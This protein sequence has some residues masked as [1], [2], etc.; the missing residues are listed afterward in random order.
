MLPGYKIA[1][2]A[3]PRLLLMFNIDTLGIRRR[4]LAKLLLEDP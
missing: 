1:A 2:I 4:T 3:D